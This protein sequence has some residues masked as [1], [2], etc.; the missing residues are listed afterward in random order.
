[1]DAKTTKLIYQAMIVP[2]FTYG[3]LALF[4][5]TPLHIES[6]IEK[7]EDRVQF[8]IGNNETIPKAEYIKKKQLC[9]FVH[10]CL[11]NDD[12]CCE[13]KEYFK[14]R[15]IS[16][17]TRWNGMKIDIPRIKLEGARKATY[18]QG[19]IIFNELPEHT[20]K[21]ADFRAFKKQLH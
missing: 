1:M 6:K 8:I 12:I 17:N 11:H 15:N 9:I 16:A 13:F 10:K 5:S 19:A 18:L 20:R 14:I 7:I 4:G 3:S 21:E 2:I